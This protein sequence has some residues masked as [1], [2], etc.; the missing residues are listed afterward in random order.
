MHMNYFIISTLLSLFALSIIE[1]EEFL[2]PFF[3]ALLVF[4]LL[5]K[6]LPKYFVLSPVFSL[7]F[8]NELITALSLEI[9]L[10][11]RW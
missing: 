6:R 4:S 7:F 3:L 2:S 9:V 1:K 5:G 10:F 8:H 11:T